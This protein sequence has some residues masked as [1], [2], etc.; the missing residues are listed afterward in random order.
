MGGSDGSNTNSIDYITMATTGNSLDF[1][2]VT[3]AETST[4][5]ITSNSRMVICSRLY[6]ID[7]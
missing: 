4:N 3:T 2:D 6:S 7:C 5:G 1:G